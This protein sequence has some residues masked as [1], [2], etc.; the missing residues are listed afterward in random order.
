MTFQSETMTVSMGGRIDVQSA[1]GKGSRFTL[2]L[3]AGSVPTT[4]R[5]LSDPSCRSSHVLSPGNDL[6]QGLHVLLVEDNPDNEEVFRNMLLPCG[7]AL[8]IAHNG[9]EAIEIVL[10]QQA[11]ESAFDV[12][13]MDMQMPVMDGF[14]ATSVLRGMGIRVPIIAVTAYAMEHQQQ[15]C[16]EAGC[17]TCLAKPFQR[18][19]LY[20]A[21]RHVKGTRT[22]GRALPTPNSLPDRTADQGF[23]VVLERYLHALR[24][25]QSR[26][27]AA[28]RV[29]DLR[30][31][32][33]ISHQLKGT[34][35]M[36]GFD[37]IG[38]AAARCQDAVQESSD[39]KALTRPIGRLKQALHVALTSSHAAGD[40]P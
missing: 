10:R 19:D 28:E 22:P 9:A 26:I 40:S 16:L 1:E 29:G 27:A 12:I 14:S 33:K 17:D 34:A 24:Q 20:S 30:E 11:A 13:L 15:Q 4:A 35:A 36:Y 38:R 6:F 3:P 7:V 2:I 23:A 31:I 32:Q 8:S 5:R 37:E 25:C 21:L 18:Q 39:I